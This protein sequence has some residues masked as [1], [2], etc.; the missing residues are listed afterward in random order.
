MKIPSVG[1]LVHLLTMEAFQHYTPGAVHFVS[2]RGRETMP[3]L[4]KTG[5]IDSLAFIGGSS[6]AD[7]L[8]RQH[9]HP[10]RL[11]IFLQLE[12]K[13][14]GIFLPNLFVETTQNNNNDNNNSNRVQEEELSQALDQAVLG[15]LSFNGQR[16]TSL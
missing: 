8:I 3:T 1:G 15:A 14:M 13:N 16:C 7:A 11:K 5:K 6:A 2:G 9:P 12:A 10:H 4:M